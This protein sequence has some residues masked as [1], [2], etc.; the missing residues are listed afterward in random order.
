M[1]IATASILVL[2]PTQK[3]IHCVS[4]SLFLSVKQSGREADKLTIINA[5]VKN[6]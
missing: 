2:G 4:G 3:L 6:A 5:E 1:L